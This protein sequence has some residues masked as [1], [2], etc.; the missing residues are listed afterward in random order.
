MTSIGI[1]KQVWTDNA[2][3]TQIASNSHSLHTK[4]SILVL[5]DCTWVQNLIFSLF[6]LSLR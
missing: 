1:L 3:T 4:W 2:I 6:T 5:W